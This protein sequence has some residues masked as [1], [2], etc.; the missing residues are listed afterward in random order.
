MN[1]IN[2]IINYKVLDK[3]YYYTRLDSRYILYNCIAEKICEILGEDNTHNI[4]MCI[5]PVAID[6]KEMV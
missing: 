5:F 4:I 3:Q 1:T 6:R 2:I